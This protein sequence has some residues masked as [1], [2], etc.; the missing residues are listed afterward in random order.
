[1]SK[2]APSK[3]AGGKSITR[4]GQPLVLPPMAPSGATPLDLNADRRDVSDRKASGL[5]GAPKVKALAQRKPK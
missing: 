4:L 3:P 1:M 5:G 2:Q